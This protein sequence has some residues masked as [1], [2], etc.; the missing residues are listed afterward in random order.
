M[1]LLR[2]LLSTPS[3]CLFLPEGTAPTDQDV[4]EGIAEKIVSVE[5][6]ADLFRIVENRRPGQDDQ[7]VIDFFTPFRQR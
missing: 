1:F 6:C 3:N 4:S 2:S 5:N 7:W